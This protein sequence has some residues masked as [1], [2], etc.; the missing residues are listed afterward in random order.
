MI[1]QDFLQPALS[2]VPH[3]AVRDLAQL[4]EILKQGTSF[5]HCHS[6]VPD[7]ECLHRI[8]ILYLNGTLLYSIAGT[9]LEARI[10][11]SDDLHLIACMAGERHIDADGGSVLMKRGSA[12]LLPTGLRHSRGC[13]SLVSIQIKP[14]AVA[15]AAAA[16]A[17]ISGYPKRRRQGLS[18]FTPLT[19]QPQGSAAPIHALIRTVT[20]WPWRIRGCPNGWASMM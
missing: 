5:S 15:M 2:C 10:D 11:H 18:R 13:Q 19:L 12:V 20:P 9:A 4:Y 7:G 17:G 16:M 3:Q 6:L 1:M 14:D 8:G